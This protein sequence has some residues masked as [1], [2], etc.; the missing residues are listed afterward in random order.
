MSV[1]YFICSVIFGKL[2][3]LPQISCIIP[4]LVGIQDF[5][6]RTKFS[7]S[8][9]QIDISCP[10]TLKLQIFSKMLGERSEK[11]IPL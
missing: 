9:V 4:H 5:L 1:L 8:L 6:Y 2:S 10:K 11:G 3:E 7:I